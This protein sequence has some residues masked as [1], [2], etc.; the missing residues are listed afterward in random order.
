MM[1]ANGGLTTPVG[2]TSVPARGADLVSRLA[3]SEVHVGDCAAIGDA[4]PVMSTPNHHAVLCIVIID[5]VMSSPKEP[6]AP[7]PRPPE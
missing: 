3:N 5:A 7:H 2:T 1:I 4:A 6:A